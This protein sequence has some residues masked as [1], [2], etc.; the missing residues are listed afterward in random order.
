MKYDYRKEITKD[1]FDYVE[2]N[3]TAEEIAEKLA[4]RE[5]FEIMLNDDLWI[6]DSVTGNA[7]GS[8]TFSRNTA[9]GYVVENMEDCIQALKEFGCEAEAVAEKFLSEDWE[10]FDVTIRCYLLG[11]C[12]GEAVDILWNK[13]AQINPKP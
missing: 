6:E 8:Y 11:E 12:V 9:K 13:Y 4:D 2:E 1:I 5:E 3:Y 10:F 7:S